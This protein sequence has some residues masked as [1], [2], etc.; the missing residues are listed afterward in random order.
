MPHDAAPHAKEAIEVGR[1]GRGLLCVTLARPD[2]GNALN[3]V[4]M[5]EISE[6]LAAA[7][8][9]SSVRLIV[10]RGQGK[11]FCGGADIAGAS[12]AA[13][14]TARL[15]PRL[16]DLLLQWDCL[17]KPTLAFVQGACIGAAVA[18]VSCCDVAIAAP[19]AFFS[20][21]EVRLGMM[22]GLLPFFVRAMGYRA[23]RRYGL[24]GERFDPETALRCGLLSEI[25][26][27]DEWKEAQARLQD[28][29]LH[30]APETLGMLKREARRFADV[31]IGPDLFTKSE[32]HDS[33]EAA[34][35]KASFK[36]K[37]KPAWYLVR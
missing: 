10:L 13:P 6:E 25:V 18:L 35:G 33:L 4:M 16:S 12:K 26:A 15:E 24:S 3:S 20:T 9:D 21:P 7:E 11:H 28:A 34:E 36:E 5:R 29:F 2:R 27:V 23:F 1:P 17:S 14:E 37:R 32:A 19:D 8:T 30:A 22:P 31:T